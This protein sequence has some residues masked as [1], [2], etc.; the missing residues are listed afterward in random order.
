AVKSIRIKRPNRQEFFR[1][2]HGSTGAY[3]QAIF[4][5]QKTYDLPAWKAECSRS[6]N[7]PPARRGEIRRSERAGAHAAATAPTRTRTGTALPATRSGGR[8]ERA[9]SRGGRVSGNGSVH[10]N[11]NGNGIATGRAR[12]RQAAARELGAEQDSDPRPEL[13]EPKG[14]VTRSMATSQARP[15][16]TRKQI[17][18]HQSVKQR[19][20]SL[21]MAPAAA[22]E[23]GQ[24]GTQPEHDDGS[25]TDAA[26]AVAAPT[27]RRRSA[28]CN[29]V[30]DLMAKRRRVTAEAQD[31]AGED[32][33]ADGDAD[34]DASTNADADATVE[35]DEADPPSDASQK[36]ADFNYK[37]EYADEYTQERCEELENLYW[38]S[39][40]YS[41]PMYGADLPGSLFDDSTTCWNVANLPNIL[42]VLGQKVPGVNTAYLYLGMWK[43]TFA[44]HVE[45]V[46]LYSINYIHFGAPKQWYSI[47][48]RDAARFEAAMRSIWPEDA[49]K[50]D[51]FLRHKN[52][53]LSPT[54]LKHDFGIEVNKLVHYEGE[55][56]VTYPYGYHS[57]YN[58]GYNCAESVNFATE[59]WLDYARVA[60]KCECVP[61][62]VWID[63][64]EL[65]RKL[66]GEPTPDPE[67]LSATADSEAEDDSDTTDS[68]KPASDL[69]T[70]PSSV[71]GKALG[72]VKRKR[73]RQPQQSARPASQARP[74][75]RHCAASP[76][77]PTWPC[78]LCP[79]D[80][81]Y[82][83][84]LPSKGGTATV[85]RTCARYFHETSITADTAGNEAVC[86]LDHIP[87]S[88]VGLKC[89]YCRETYGACVR[90]AH[91]NCGRVYHPTCA[92][93]AGAQAETGRVPVL[94]ADGKEYSIEAVD[95]RCK[96]HRNKR[97]IASA[98]ATTTPQEV[99]L[100]TKLACKA[101]PGDLIQFQTDRQIH[102]AQVVENRL[103]EKTLLVRL[104]PDAEHVE[105]PYGNLCFV[106]VSKF[107]PLPE[108]ILPLPAH[109][110][111]EI[112][113][114]EE[115][116]EAS[117]PMAGSRF[118]KDSDLRWAE[119]SALEIK[120]PVAAPSIDLFQPERLWF[121]LGEESTEAR[122]HYTDHPSRREKNAK[123]DFLAH[124]RAQA[125][126]TR[127]KPPAAQKPPPSTP[128][129]SP[130]KRRPRPPQ[131]T[132]R[133][134]LSPPPQ[135]P[136][137]PLVPWEAPRRYDQYARQPVVT[138][139][140]ANY[141]VPIF[142][143]AEPYRW[144]LPARHEQPPLVKAEPQARR[145]GRA[146]DAGTQANDTA[147]AEL[148]RALA[149]AG[150]YRG[151]FA[152]IVQHAN[153]RAGYTM[154]DPDCAV[155]C[156]LAA[157]KTPAPL[158]GIEKLI[159]TMSS[160]MVQ[161]RQPGGFTRTVPIKMDSQEVQDLIQTLRLAL[162]GLI[163]DS[164]QVSAKSESVSGH[165]R[166]S[167]R[168][169]CVPPQQTARYAYLEMQQCSRPPLYQSP[170]SPDGSFSAHAE[171]QY[172]IG[173]KPP[174]A[175]RRRNSAAEFFNSLSTQDQR[176]VLMACGREVVRK[177]TS[178]DGTVPVTMEKQEAHSHAV[179]PQ[180]QP[181]VQMQVQ[182][183]R[184]E[185]EMEGQRA[186]VG[187]HPAGSHTAPPWPPQQQ[188]QQQP[189]QSQQRLPSQSQPQLH[190]HDELETRG[191]LYA[192]SPPSPF[193]AASPAS[194]FGRPPL[195]EYSH[196]SQ[197]QLMSCSLPPI[198]YGEPSPSLQRAALHDGGIDP[199]TL[200]SPL[201]QDRP[202]SYSP[203]PGS[204]RSMRAGD[205]M[206]FG[207]ADIAGFAFE[208]IK[209]KNIVRALNY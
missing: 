72:G 131:P 35:A 68:S 6:Q 197:A 12:T 157:L 150:S 128:R 11:G 108:G 195:H 1:A 94:A 17:G 44:W 71:R 133:P 194:S 124:I 95:L 190:H 130:E 102:G 23:S 174:R 18:Q 127:R 188:Q 202:A 156:L 192:P 59:R 39:L 164:A 20:H 172:G 100:Q 167:S 86:H 159:G 107:S 53:L 208:D 136:P 196:M 117:V 21:R 142:P 74:W 177:Q 137:P 65:E 22:S 92:L 60:K 109:L 8:L 119:F 149:E 120:S 73:P 200:A 148:T 126:A 204:S 14:R 36:A 37:L 179:Q 115:E 97:G 112:D 2:H 160:S 3:T 24:D 31:G 41:N 116:I 154:I 89:F 151:L 185:V 183:A 178:S 63:V 169:S 155:Q 66:R 189:Q 54:R 184:V 168:S 182:I 96:Y 51:Q 47:S 81:D 134:Q 170:Y 103:A 158:S 132:P 76:T 42:N 93:L 114:D 104:L 55:F 91:A 84:L 141:R 166:Q 28:S 129:R 90:C 187:D 176:K 75:K 181:Q 98:A 62:S 82:E 144:P 113:D 19:R 123:A 83:P 138:L 191:T 85:H 48:Q 203:S 38:K 105:I 10:G 7:Q 67:P 64:D 16:R 58:L 9:S 80:F 30:P 201:P 101:R 27:R 207:A 145:A 77:P 146:V 171:Q 111:R 165:S 186:L 50:C 198:P 163:S 49:K 34:V 43:A 13:E 162:L 175:H 79:N 4:E 33:D 15:P 147:G 209:L 206:G 25:E 57:G 29:V 143:T 61:D 88:H 26:P 122:A 5:K 52:Y 69:L 70:P 110:T 153:E 40:F 99:L 32:L 45:D 87:D 199:R 140:C 125:K 78:A 139:E 193:R 161:R 56:V 106:R 121:Y 118:T 46:D 135:L 152:S 173:T 180:P 205:L